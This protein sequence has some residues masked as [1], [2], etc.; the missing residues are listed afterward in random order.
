MTLCT[1]SPDITFSV[2][3]LHL[4]EATTG[5]YRADKRAEL[6]ICLTI[7][8]IAHPNINYLDVGT[9]TGRYPE[10][11]GSLFSHSYAI[12]KSCDAVAL[13]KKRHK[14]ITFRVLDVSKNSI[15]AEF[16]KKFCFMTMMMGTINHI[17]KSSHRAALKN[18]RDALA[19]DGCIVLSYLRCE[20][21]YDVSDLYNGSELSYLISNKVDSNVIEDSELQVDQSHDIEAFRILVLRHKRA[22]SA[23]LY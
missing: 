8:K 15:L 6:N 19:R 7:A 11:L 20:P 18:M 13:C 1:N 23:D 5:G 10:T 17:D 14:N 12:D 4:F 2:D 22:I 9:C 21:P 3:K 16:G